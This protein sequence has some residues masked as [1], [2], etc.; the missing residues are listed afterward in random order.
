MM[1]NDVESYVEYSTSGL[2]NVESYVEYST[3]VL[4][5]VDHVDWSD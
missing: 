1:L 3:L 5:D 4:N 2:N